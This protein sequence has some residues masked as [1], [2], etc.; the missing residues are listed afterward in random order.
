MNVPYNSFKNMCS[1]LVINYCRKVNINANFKVHFEWNGNNK[2]WV[3]KAEVVLV[4]INHECARGRL[5]WS[6]RSVVPITLLLH[7]DLTET[8]L[9]AYLTT[10]NE[11]AQ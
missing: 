8:K 1:L 4:Q 2:F 6:V 7:S 11:N 10:V 3:A 5:V 9:P